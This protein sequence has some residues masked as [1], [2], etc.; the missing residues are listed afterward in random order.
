MTPRAVQKLFQKYRPELEGHYDDKG[1]NGTWL[2]DTAQELLRSKMKMK[3]VVLYDA[4]ASPLLAEL[5]D[6]RRENEKLRNDNSDAYRQLA[7]SR[8]YQLQLQAQLAEQKQLVAGKVE[9]DRKAAEAELALEEARSQIQTI[10]CIAEA[11]GQEAEQ[12]KAEAEELRRQLQAAEEQRSALEA[13]AKLPWWK[14]IKKPDF[15]AEK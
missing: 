3:P 7:Q 5:E 10:E 9:S 12:A 13:Y 2:D 15:E 8:E 6:L 1:H 14:K 4:S 11:N